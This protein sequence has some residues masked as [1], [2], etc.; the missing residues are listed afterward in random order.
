ME[1]GKQIKKYRNKMNLS[2][3]ILA[4]KLFVSRQ[5]ISNWENNKS[6][7][8]VENLLR[9]S[10]L[11][12]ISLDV[13]VK[14]DLEEMKKLIKKEDVKKFERDSNIF[15]IL[16]FSMMIFPIPLYVFMKVVGSIIWVGITI[17]TFYYALKVEK[18][19]KD[20]DIQTYKEILAFLEGEELGDSQKHQEIGKRKYQKFLI[21]AGFT[22]LAVIIS[23]VML[24]IL[25]LIF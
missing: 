11:F 8:D 14:G 2:Q 19:K 13:L 6:Y 25:S 5:T 17:A 16:F 9:L 10:S 23:A 18:Q 15:A 20:Y 12:N 24:L 21:V 4:E 7:P 1:I 22:L 3:E